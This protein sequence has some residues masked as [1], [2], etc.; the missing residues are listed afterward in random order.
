[1][2][3]LVDLAHSNEWDDIV[4]TFEEYDVYYLSGYVKAFQIHGDGDPQLLY[5]EVDGLKAIY[6]YMKRE[7][8]IEGYYDS[9]TP[10]GYGGVLFEGDMSEL[11]Q[12]DMVRVAFNGMS[13]HQTGDEVRIGIVFKMF[14]WTDEASQDQPATVENPVTVS[15]EELS[16]IYDFI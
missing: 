13:M 15:D 14:R 10:Y 11:K 12:G 5:Y 16:E 8:A 3:K 7:T 6:V 4:K 1:M 2:I 9:V